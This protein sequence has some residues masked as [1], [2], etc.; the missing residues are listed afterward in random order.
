MKPKKLSKKEIK[1][2]QKQ[3]PKLEQSKK[4]RLQNKIEMIVIV[5][6]ISMI[7][8]FLYITYLM[9]IYQW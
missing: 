9:V 1:E 6:E 2:L 5:F 3:F 7:L 8:L 4:E